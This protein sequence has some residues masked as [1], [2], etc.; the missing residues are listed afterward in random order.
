MRRSLL[1][2]FNKSHS[3]CLIALLLQVLNHSTFGDGKIRSMIP[4]NITLWGS[5]AL[6][7][8]RTYHKWEIEKRFQ[9]CSLTGLSPSCLKEPIW[10]KEK[11]S[12]YQCK[13]ILPYIL[14]YKR[15][16][17]ETLIIQ[18]R[19]S[20]FDQDYTENYELR[21]KN[22]LTH[23][24]PE[25]LQLLE[26]VSSL[27]FLNSFSN[28]CPSTDVDNIIV[29]LWS[30]NKANC[31]AFPLSQ[32]IGIAKIIGWSSIIEIAFELK[33]E[34][35]HTVDLPISP[36]GVSKSAACFIPRLNSYVYPINSTHWV[37]AMVD[38]DTVSLKHFVKG[39]TLI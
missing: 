17:S 21:L 20:Y 37:S 5:S 31:Q 8:F 10:R 16:T 19:H 12:S 26:G 2:E 22:S 13:T 33:D 7:D 30:I 38:D 32:T 14:N 25:S 36:G 35:I 11:F 18:Q 29:D 1:I 24:H 34:V 15:L 4:V 3:F 9:S 28:S 27:L 23:Y 39:W 6:L